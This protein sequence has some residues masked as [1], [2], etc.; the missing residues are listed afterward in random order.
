[1]FMAHKD[2][3]ERD[4]YNKEYNKKYYIKNKKYLSQKKKDKFKKEYKPKRKE[5]TIEILDERKKIK[6]IYQ[7]NYQKI[8]R[9][10]FRQIIFDILDNK[11]AVCGFSNKKALQIDHISGGG[12]KER[13][14]ISNSWTFYKKVIESLNDNKKEYQL[15]CANCNWI[16]RVDNNE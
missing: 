15:L 8:S 14:V 13:K 2:K 5:I 9:R 11:C 1:M 12:S 7:N 3:V 16:K 6:R 4:K 10:N